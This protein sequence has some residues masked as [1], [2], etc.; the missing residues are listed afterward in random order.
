MKLLVDKRR[1][2]LNPE[3]FLRR[4]GFALIRDRQNNAFSFVRRLSTGFYPRFHLYLDDLGA[5]IALN[6]HLDQKKA[7]YD[8]SARHSGEYDGDLVVQEMARLEALL[9][10]DSVES[11]N[12]SLLTKMGHGGYDEEEEPGKKPNFWQ[13]LFS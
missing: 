4:A 11:V 7:S 13:R 6:L 5:K 3:L 9:L 10:P 8:G 12:G 1:F 2:P